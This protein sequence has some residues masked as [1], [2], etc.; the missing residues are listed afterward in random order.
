M[1]VYW[2]IFGNWRESIYLIPHHCETLAS[3]SFEKNL[4]KSV[5]TVQFEM[6]FLSRVQNLPIF[7]PHRIEK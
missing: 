4:D 5:F 2:L 6:K 3:F 1:T 7:G